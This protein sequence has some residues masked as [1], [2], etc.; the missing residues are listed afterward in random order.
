MSSMFE[1]CISLEKIKLENF[2]TVKLENMSKMFKSCLILIDL[3]ISK[4]KLKR[5][6]LADFV[7]SQCSKRLKKKIRNQIYLKDE[8]YYDG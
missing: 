1:N 5:L 6:F 8:A 7:F 3:D 2:N 4:F